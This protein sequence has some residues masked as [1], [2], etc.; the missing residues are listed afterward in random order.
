MVINGRIIPIGKSILEN[1]DFDLMMG[2]QRPEQTA[3]EKNTTSV[4][5]KKANHFWIEPDELARKGIDFCSLE[6]QGLWLKVMRLLHASERYGYLSRD[7]K[8]VSDEQAAR[9]CGLDVQ[10][11]LSLVAELVEFDLLKRSGDGILF[12]PELVA[13][14]EWRASGA[15][16]Q[17][18]FQDKKKR[19]RYNGKYN[20]Q[21]NDDITPDITP[22]SRSNF[23]FKNTLSPEGEK[24]GGGKPPPA[25]G[26][27]QQNYCGSENLAEYLARKQAEFPQHN[28]AEIYEDFSEKCGSE[29]YPKL[30]NTW[31]FFDRWLAEQDL[32]FEPAAR[33]GSYKN[34]HTGKEMK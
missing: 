10:A 23:K 29:R 19:E 15:R 7:G 13:Q 14:A 4:M 33:N 24:S 12:S 3:N 22:E 11:W 17:K 6:A 28:V 1:P 9:R 16:R 21:Y 26:S 30:R 20:G 18:T 2:L 8:A 27:S 5:A 34:P 31:R 25:A 32:E